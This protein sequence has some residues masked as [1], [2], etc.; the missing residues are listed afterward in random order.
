MD[1]LLLFASSLLLLPQCQLPSA[2]LPPDSACS[3]ACLLNHL[4]ARSP[5][6]LVPYLLGLLPARSPAWSPACSVL[7]LP[8]PL[9]ARSPACSVLCLPGPL[10]ARS[11]AC[12]VPCLLGPLPARSIAC[13]CLVT[14]WPKMDPVEPDPVVKA[15]TNQGAILGQHD[16]LLRNLMESQ[17]TTSAQIAQLNSMVREL[18]T[19]LSQSAAF[20]QSSA[21][22]NQAQASSD[23]AQLREAHVPDPNHYQGDMGKCGGF[24]LQCS[25]V[26][27]QKPIT[28]A[29]DSSK[30][31]YVMGLLQGNALDWA[32]AKWQSD[33][34]IQRSYDKFVTELKRVFDHPV[35]GKEAAKRLLTI[36]QGSRS[37]AE[38]SVE[39]RTLAAEAGWDDAALQTVFVN[40]LSEQLKDELALKDDFG[41][42]NSVISTAIKLD[43]RLRERKRE[44]NTRPS[45][46]PVIARIS[47]VPRNSVPSAAAP[48]PPPAHV[49]AEEPMQLG[50]AHLTPA[51]RLRR[52]RAGECIYC[53]KLGH[54]LATCP[55]RP[56]EGLTS[57]RGGS[58]LID[59]GADEN[60]LDVDLACQAQLEVETLDV[61]LVANALDGRLLAKSALSPAK[62]APVPFEPSD[63]SNVPSEYH[64]LQEVFSKD[65]AL[66]LPPHRPYDC[67]IDLLPGA[68][69]PSSRL[70]NLSRPE[71]EAMERY[72][73]DSLTADPSLQF[74]VEVDASDS[75]VGAVLSQRSPVDQ[76][77]HPCAFFSR[78]LS[79]AEHNYSIGDRELLAVKLAL[80]EWRHYLEG[81]EHPFVVW[82][83]H[84]NLAYIKTAKRLNSRQARW[85]LFFGRFNF[86]LTFR[87]GSH[88]VKSDA[89]SRQFVSAESSDEAETIVPASCVVAMVTWEIQSLVEEAQKAEPDPGNGP[90]NRQFVPKAVRSQV[91]QWGHTSR[92]AC[93]PGTRRT[94]VL[95]KRHFWWPSMEKD[96]RAYISACTVCARG[97]STN[98]R[99]AGCLRPLPVP[100]RPWSHIALDFITG[101]PLSQGN[102]VILTIVDRF[103]KSVHFIA[104][105][106]L[107]SAQETADLLVQ[108]IFR[109]HGIP[110]DI[111]SDRGP[112]FISKV[113]KCFCEALGAKV[114]LTSGFHPQTNGQCERANQDLETALRCVAAQEPSSWSRHLPWVEYAHNS[115]TSS[116]TGLSPF[117]CALGYLPPLFPEQEGDIAV[118]SVKDNLQ[119]CRHVWRLTRAALLRSA[120]QNKKIA[121]KHRTPAPNYKPGDKVWLSSRDIPLKIDS[122]KL[123]PRYIG[124]F[125]IE[126]VLNPTVVRLKL[127][128]SLRIHP[129]FHVSQLKPVRSS[130]LC[131]PADPPPPAQVVDD[132]PAFTVRQILDVR[133]R[134]RGFQYLVDWEGYGPEE[135]SWVSRPLILD[136][137]L[138]SDFYRLNPDKP[139]GS[140]GGVH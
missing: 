77:V 13:T 139:G 12:S 99:P 44:R 26:F 48:L 23:P 111:V 101:L 86:T 27:S 113:W 91:I 76:K 75:G 112:Q 136:P 116:A 63:L 34:E 85:A 97:K 59:S 43:N 89:L 122:K 49:S 50:R 82:T 60:F 102:S 2:C 19:G 64:D 15:I 54:F 36:H 131:P 8:G 120:E 114:S 88:N 117:E 46:Q 94:L 128:S 110:M 129:S 1:P 124:P 92:F 45:S 135:R 69:L 140:P 133:R 18:T 105:A 119:R 9:P 6:C 115:L 55:S 70:Y 108:H 40:G 35:K 71:R 95:L 24:L 109:I 73:K 121:D 7:S 126:K 83:D 81:A 107:P 25:F 138:L 33:P 78:R 39:F 62:A 37:V 17:Q 134:G 103:S 53:G 10:P 118:P 38:Y 137:G 20:S 74:I 72:I 130:P 14:N 61:P 4:P 47:Q 58:A 123:A 106:K 30:I 3:F 100:S 65:R 80:E 125:E 57:E 79:P 132:Y 11:P 98:Q 52:I 42:F 21:S 96:I 104:L 90:H 5:A 68:T 84:K 93:H 41:D 22:Q 31:A 51:E 16:Q 87:P 66:S 28:Y 29:T 56:K 127:P 67:A 32:Y